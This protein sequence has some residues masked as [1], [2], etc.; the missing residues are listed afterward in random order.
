MALEN[1]YPTSTNISVRRISGTNNYELEITS[2]SHGIITDHK[3]TIVENLYPELDV[4]IHGI[5][6]YYYPNDYES[7]TTLTAYFD[8]QPYNLGTNGGLNRLCAN[9]TSLQSFDIDE[10]TENNNDFSDNSY[11]FYN[12]TSLTHAIVGD[13]LDANDIDCNS[14]FE[15][16]SN[17]MSVLKGVNEEAVITIGSDITKY[18]DM[19]KGCNIVSQLNFRDPNNL[20]LTEIVD[21]QIILPGGSIY[22]VPSNIHYGYELLGL[23]RT[24]QF[25]I[26]SNI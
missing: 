13:I 3:T 17:L 12:C 23:T 15:G 8:G 1:I 10:V 25:T 2:Y 11:A 22:A 19:F 4:G 20:L 18:V 7:I 6:E 16:C 5:L 26:I 24:E 21:G 14:M 9:C